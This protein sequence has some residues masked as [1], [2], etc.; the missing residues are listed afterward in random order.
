MGLGSDSEPVPI[1][2][3]GQQTHLADSIQF[4]LEYFLRIQNHASGV[5]YVNT[6]FPGEDPDAMH[7]NQFCHIECE[8]VGA[9]SRGVEVAE[10][11]IIGFVSILLQDFDELIT[12]VVGAIDHLTALID[13]Y[14]F[15]GG[16]FP[17]ITLDDAL[18]LP[19]MDDGCWKHVLPDQPE[20]G[21]AITRAG[22]RKLIEK[23]GGAVWLTE[24]NHLSVPF[25]QAFTDDTH[26]KAR[27]ADFLLGNGEVL[28]I[29]ERH[30]SS[31]DVRD[32][33]N[34]HEV[35]SEGYSWYMEIRDRKSILTTGWGMGIERFLAW[36]L[37]HNDIRDLTMVPRMKGFR[38]TPNNS[39]RSLSH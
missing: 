6:S 39:F 1:C 34:E 8:L 12:R 11:Y 36:V 26:R 17:Q 37:K 3:L 31:M 27:C 33:L 24:M 29:G 4:S 16:K 10:R 13:L 9:F 2:F 35:P 21:R 15:G 18:Q 32:A 28:G 25:Y 19:F 7:L 20:K 38:F 5:Y 23:L 30:K 14:R 22:E